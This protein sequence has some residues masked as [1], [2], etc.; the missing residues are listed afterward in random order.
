MDTVSRVV[1]DRSA[2]QLDVGALLHR[3]AGPVIAADGSGG[4]VHRRVLAGRDP[5]AGRIKWTC[6]TISLDDAP[7]RTI[8]LQMAPFL[9]DNPVCEVPLDGCASSPSQI[10]IAQVPCQN[11]DL[12]VVL[13]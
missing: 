1:R 4:Q 10:H 12:C 11:P 3:D 6:R 8:D 5:T 7:T 9:E 2:G 13:N